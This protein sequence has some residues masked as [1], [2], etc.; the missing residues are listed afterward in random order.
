MAPDAGDIERGA[1][2]VAGARYTKFSSTFGN[3]FIDFTFTLH[4]SNTNA[5][6]P[7]SFTFRLLL[8]KGKEGYLHFTRFECNE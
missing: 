6:L 1:R 7:A 8:G 2:L 3:V 4:I 5:T